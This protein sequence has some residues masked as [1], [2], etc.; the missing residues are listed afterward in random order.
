MAASTPSVSYGC[1][2]GGQFLLQD[3]IAVTPLAFRDGALQVP[4]GPG[5][6]IAINEEKVRTYASDGFTLTAR[7][8]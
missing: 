7:E 5:L 6:G 4:Q 8:A 2:L 3:D 1:E